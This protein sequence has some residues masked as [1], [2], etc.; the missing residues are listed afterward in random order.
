MIKAWE[1]DEFVLDPSRVTIFIGQTGIEGDTFKRRHLMDRFGVQINKTSRNT[2]LFMTTIGTSR[3]SVAYLIE[4]LV[5]IARELDV[6]LAD[7][8][9]AER[10]AH[11][12]AV[13]RLTAPSAP[14]P[15]FSGFHPSFT[16][17]QGVPT[18]DGD[19]R[20]AFYLSYNDSYCEY[21]MPDEVEQR[22]ENGDQVVSTTYVTPYPP[23]FPVLVPGQ[24][25]SRQILAFMRSLDTP[26]VH[27][28]RP[29]LG[30]RVY[31]D[32]A[33]EIAATARPAPPPSTAG[34]LA[35]AGLVDPVESGPSPGPAASAS[36]PARPAKARRTSAG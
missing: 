22:V 28:Y 18:P 9:L 11:E 36:G 20:R 8:S 29:E 15:D 17:G 12:R 3:S 21:L 16:D 30:Y 2:V 4:V 25:F 32:K 14:L 1:G 10:G 23:G 27:G 19:V 33:L 34:S 6:E 31:V 5:T 24:V 7:M 13:L 26:E 35:S